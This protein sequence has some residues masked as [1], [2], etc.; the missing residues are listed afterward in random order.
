MGDILKKAIYILLL[1]L[2]LFPIKLF[3]KYDVVDARCTNS[4]KASLRTDAND[5][6]YRLSKEI[7]GD[8]VTYKAI[9]YNLTKDMYLASSNGETYNSNVIKDLEPGS[10][11]Q[12]II[13]A[14]NSTYCEGYKI[15]TK[16]ISV[17]YYNKYYKNELCT[18]YENYYLCKENSNV[19]LSEK[20]F[21]KKMKEYIESL[22]NK[23]K[24]EV[25]PQEEV[26]KFDIIGFVLLYKYFFIGG[27]LLVLIIISI[28]IINNKRK[29][30]GIL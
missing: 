22:E 1:L 8:K 12:I 10:T 20:E 15:I 25:K 11:L 24:E 16:I 14:S 7:K 29:N 9:F 17:P 19:N 2:L 30:R 18:G 3:A 21:E 6:I 23:E 4:I 28:I 13:Y 27:F 26:T 5:V